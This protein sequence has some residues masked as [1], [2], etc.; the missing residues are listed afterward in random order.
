MTERYYIGE[1]NV[2]L[3]ETLSLEQQEAHH[4][5]KVMRIPVGAQVRLFGGGQ[6]FEA[7]VLATRPS[8]V[9]RVDRVLTPFTELSGYLI[10]AVPWLRS[11]KTEYLVQKLTE[12]GVHEIAVFTAERCTARGDE[13]KILR[14]R[15][16]AIEACKQCERSSVPRISARSSTDDVVEWMQ[17][18][19]RQV[20]SLAERVDAVIFSRYLKSSHHELPVSSTWP[21]LGI[22]TGPEGG[23]SERELAYLAK[24]TTLASLGR[25][26]LRADFAPLVATIL[27]LAEA[28]EL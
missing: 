3:G 19:V 5:A 6:E 14:L 11:S 16:I 4:L 10:V 21:Q 12:L 1:A 9:V 8:V 25:R 28:G 15:R 26:I 13:K 7:T 20:V 23:F 22:I 27:V 18:S 17:H 24:H 2:K